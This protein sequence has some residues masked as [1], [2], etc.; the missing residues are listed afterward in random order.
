MARLGRFVLP[1]IPHHVTQRGN[2]RQQTFFCDEDYIAYRNLLAEHCNAQG[3]AVWSWVLM[4]NHVHLIL[5]PEHEDALRS[6]LSKVHRAFAG[7]SMRAKRFVRRLTGDC[8][9][10]SAKCETRLR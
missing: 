10:A 9:A 3:V 1:G 4:P 6:A 7:G 2:G 8:L 5:L